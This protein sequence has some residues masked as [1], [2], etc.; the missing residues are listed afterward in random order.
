MNEVKFRAW[1]KQRKWMVKVQTINFEINRVTMYDKNGATYF[2][3]FRDV[4]LLQFTGLRDKNRKKIYEGDVI[5][6]TLGNIGIVSFSCGEFTL[7]ID[8]NTLINLTD[9]EIM[10][11]SFCRDYEEYNKWYDCE[12]IGN[13][14]ENP[15]LWKKIETV[16]SAEKERTYDGRIRCDNCKGI[17][18]NQIPFG[19]EVWEFLENNKEI[20]CR[21][22]GCKLSDGLM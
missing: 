11:E 19:T 9:K 18:H 20:K 7:L 3:F 21:Y 12:I 13:K 8:T 2:E 16:D 5:R 4:E 15:E 17:N 1:D 6:D 22:C 10:K 14:Y